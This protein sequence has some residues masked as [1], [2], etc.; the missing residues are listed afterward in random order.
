MI[1][2]Y[3]PFRQKSSRSFALRLCKSSYHV[4]SL[5][6][7]LGTVR[8]FSDGKPSTRRLPMAQGRARSS[9]GTYLTLALDR[10]RRRFMVD[11]LVPCCFCRKPLNL[12]LAAVKDITHSMLTTQPKAQHWSPSYYSLSISSLS[13]NHL[14]SCLFGQYPELSLWG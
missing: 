9:S 3:L 1:H 4:P 13:S 2:D 10:R 5:S 14:N 11:A 12:K 6:L 7:N 8:P